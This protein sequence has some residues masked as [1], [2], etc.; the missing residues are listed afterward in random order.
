LGMK[1]IT[2]SNANATWENASSKISYY[3]SHSNTDSE[4]VQVKT[5]K[6]QYQ[7]V[8]EWTVCYTMNNW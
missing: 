3:E 8:T 1:P 6:E 5:I 7:F 4:N 2:V